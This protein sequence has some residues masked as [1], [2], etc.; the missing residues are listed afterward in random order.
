MLSVVIETRNDEETLARTLAS[1]VGGAVGG[2][3]REVIVCDRGSTDRTHVV[4]DHTGCRYMTNSTI[5]AG[6]RQAKGEW[7]VLLRPGARLCEGW[8]EAVSDHVTTSTSAARF[9]KMANGTRLFR[10]VFARRHP[11][12]EGLVITR[13]QAAA[14]TERGRD[15][16]TIARRLSA[17]R[18]GAE[19][20]PAPR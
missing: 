19:I 16:D 8:M 2:M 6:V 7:L 5:A 14:L 12:A 1:L 13:R 15:A 3:V 4:A 10:G 17:K 20:V 9:K 18:L 11:L